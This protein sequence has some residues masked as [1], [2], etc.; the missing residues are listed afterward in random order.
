MPYAIGAPLLLTSVW[1]HDCKAG[2]GCSPLKT[3]ELGS[4][5]DLRSKF[6][7]FLNASTVQRSIRAPAWA[8]PSASGLLS[9]P[10]GASGWNPTQDGVRHFTLRSSPETLDGNLAPIRASIL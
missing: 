1:R 10:A 5:P 9:A 3:T 2:S 8:S 7:K 4:T 6:L